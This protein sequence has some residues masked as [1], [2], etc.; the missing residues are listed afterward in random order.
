MLADSE[1]PLLWTGSVILPANGSD[2][3]GRLYVINWL[4]K[5]YGA[6]FLRLLAA[7]RVSN[8]HKP[9]RKQY[10]TFLIDTSEGCWL[11]A[12]WIPGLLSFR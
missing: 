8:Q 10:S 7:F 2:F 9:Y 4:G 5:S 6:I 11:Q 3:D 12:D 1:I